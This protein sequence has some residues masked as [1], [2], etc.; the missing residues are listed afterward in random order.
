M[1][2]ELEPLDVGGVDGDK[3]LKVTT[4]GSYFEAPEVPPSP[5][6]IIVLSG[7]EWTVIDDPIYQA[8]TDLYIFTCRRPDGTKTNPADF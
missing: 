6:D 3:R 1:S 8:G 2:M 7:V 5:G 4:L